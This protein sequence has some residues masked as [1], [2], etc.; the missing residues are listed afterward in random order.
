[1]L[2]ISTSIAADKMPVVKL[3]GKLLTPWLDEVREAC[4]SAQGEAAQCFALDL[5]AL[6][7]VEPARIE[8]LQELLRRGARMAGCSRFVAELLNLKL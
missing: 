5:T 7:Y 4:C 3:E 8:L 6:T 2:R 1:M